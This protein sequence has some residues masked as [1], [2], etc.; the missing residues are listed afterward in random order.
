[1]PGGDCK[2]ARFCDD[3]ESYATG[4]APTGYGLR[5]KGGTLTIE[6]SKAFSGTRSVYIKSDEGSAKT[7]A[8]INVGRGILPLPGNVVHGRMMVYLTATPQGNVHWDNTI[9]SGKLP[10]TDVKAQYAYGGH[11]SGRFIV[12]YN[13]HDCNAIS[14]T[15]FPTGRWACLQWQFDGPSMTTRLWVD[16]KAIADQTVVGKTNR[17]MDR[18]GAEWVAP[19]F[20]NAQFGWTNYQPSPVPIEMWMDDIAI[21]SKQIACPQLP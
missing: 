9:W 7:T 3:F 6:S 12:V 19:T 21:D 11:Q 18:S 5:Q 16:G 17:C 10:G 4:Q 2:V 20:D 1:M 14:Q 13:P 8:L 15:P